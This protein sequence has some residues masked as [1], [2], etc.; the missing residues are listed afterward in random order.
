MKFKNCFDLRVLGIIGSILLI[1]TEFLPW[2]SDRSCLDIYL[3]YTVVA[4]EDSFLYLFPLISGIIGLIGSILILYSEEFRINSVII[5]FL[6]LGFLTF[7]LFKIVSSDLFLISNIS[8]G[9]YL[10]LVGFLIVVI[11][12]ILILRMKDLIFSEGN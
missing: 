2:F 9:F 10:C 7:F 4:V 8:V 12:V 5:S 1:I 11:N 3:L 6:G